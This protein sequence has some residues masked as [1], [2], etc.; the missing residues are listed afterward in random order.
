MDG[1]IIDLGKAANW[2]VIRKAKKR[3]YITSEELDRLLPPETATPQQVDD[4]V[5]QLT[6]AGI[7]L[8][9]VEEHLGS[10]IDPP[11]NSNEPP[12]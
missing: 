6:E 7:A 2:K 12:D 10:H 1:P 4:V 5:N 8:V 3:G 11:A 9:E